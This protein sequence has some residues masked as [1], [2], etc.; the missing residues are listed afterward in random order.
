[1]H[2]NKLSDSIEHYLKRT[3]DYNKLSPEEMILVKHNI[4]PNIISNKDS[5]YL[6]SGD[7][8]EVFDV[9][10]NG[11]N[12]IAKIAK[13]FRNIDNLVDLYKIK[14]SLGPLGKHIAEIYDV[15]EYDEIID[16]NRYIG[17]IILVEKLEPLD[18]SIKKFLRGSSYF[19]HTTENTPKNFKDTFDKVIDIYKNPLIYFNFIQSHSGMFN[20]NISKKDI[21]ECSNLIVHF[22]S[23]V[24]KLSCNNLIS[25]YDFKER[26]AS[27]DALEEIKKNFFDNKDKLK[28]ILMIIEPTKDFYLSFFDFIFSIIKQDLS[29]GLDN[30]YEDAEKF[31]SFTRYQ[32]YPELKSILKLFKILK[33]NY[34]VYF[35]DIHDENLMQRPGTKDVVIS[36]PGLFSF[37]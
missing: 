30:D 1:L 19:F 35:R 29:E 11:K 36:D 17:Y 28:K 26:L 15:I 32:K 24:L 9:M 2:F 7:Y 5:S 37:K 21:L 33:E 22:I 10:Y 16:E 3:I 27:K 34:N 12:C 6:G 20:A 18:P 13:D 14:V 8:S 25:S 31:D 4:T 23:Q